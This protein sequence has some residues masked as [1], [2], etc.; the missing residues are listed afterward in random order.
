MALLVGSRLGIG[1]SLLTK[2]RSG[3]VADF[4]ER[5]DKALLKNN[6][7]TVSLSSGH[8]LLHSYSCTELYYLPLMPVPSATSFANAIRSRRAAFASLF[9]SI[10]ESV[11]AC[12][13][14]SFVRSLCLSASLLL[15]L[16]LLYMYDSRSSP[17]RHSLNRRRGDEKAIPAPSLSKV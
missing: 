17:F 8:I 10:P 3:P 1:A 5:D 9:P 2:S 16:F 7:S 6:C 15:L 14:L 11:P 13:R 12:L 4:D